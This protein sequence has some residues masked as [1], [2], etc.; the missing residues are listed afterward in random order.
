MRYPCISIKESKIQNN[1]NTQFDKNVQPQ[2]LSLIP[3]RKEKQNNHF[4]RQL[5]NFF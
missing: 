5:C 2:E 3:G 4:G 1:D